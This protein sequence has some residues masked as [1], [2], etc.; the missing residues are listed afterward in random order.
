MAEKQQRQYKIE[1]V[2]QEKP[3]Q[4]EQQNKMEDPLNQLPDLSSQ[5]GGLPIVTFVL[6]CL[7]GGCVMFAQKLFTASSAVIIGISILMLVILISGMV[8]LFH[9]MHEK[10]RN[11]GAANAWYVISTVIMTIGIGIGIVCGVIHCF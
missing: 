7:A 6:I 11:E 9:G 2:E 4:P 1:C 5:T 10:L 3:T 8:A